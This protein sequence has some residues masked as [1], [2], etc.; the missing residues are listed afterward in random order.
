MFSDRHFPLIRSRSILKDN[1]EYSEAPTKSPVEYQ[2]LKDA[3]FT[4]DD[5]EIWIELGMRRGDISK[6]LDNPTFKILRYYFDDP[7]DLPDGFAKYV[8]APDPDKI[9]KLLGEITTNPEAHFLAGS[10]Y[11][12]AIAKRIGNLLDVLSPEDIASV[13]KLEIS[14]QNLGTFV[15]KLSSTNQWKIVQRS[16]YFNNFCLSFRDKLT[17]SSDIL[18][19]TAQ[20]LNCSIVISLLI[21]SSDIIPIW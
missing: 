2:E 1:A 20:I 19:R 16:R 6:M 5:I 17:K 15:K 11:S 13:T 18:L 8:R 7:E 14:K 9:T 4:N 12:D 3:I 21:V 10:P